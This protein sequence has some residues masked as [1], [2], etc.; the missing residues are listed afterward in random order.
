MVI[1]PSDQNRRRRLYLTFDI[2]QLLASKGI[3]SNQLMPRHHDPDNMPTIEEKKDPVFPI[4]LPLKVR[5]HVWH[6]RSISLLIPQDVSGNCS[7]LSHH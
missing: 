7:T 3:D 2:A 5:E 4:Y 6:L 1:S